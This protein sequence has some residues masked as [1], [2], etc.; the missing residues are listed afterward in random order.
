MCY[1]IIFT[2]V[3]LHVARPNLGNL[4]IIVWTN[5]EGKQEYFRLQESIC[6]KWVLIGDLLHI[7]YPL[8]DA[9]KKKWDG[10][11]LNCIREVLT[12]WLDNGPHTYPVSWEGVYELLDDAELTNFVVLLKEAI[13]NAQRKLYFTESVK[14]IMSDTTIV[15]LHQYSYTPDIIILQK[16]AIHY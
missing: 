4:A 16:Y 15:I 8:L 2:Y 9:W 10:D 1:S 13:E 14:I 5:K 6:D 12:Y 7:R 11:P 3:F